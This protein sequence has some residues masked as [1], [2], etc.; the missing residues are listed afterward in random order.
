M[1][2]LALARTRLSDRDLLAEVVRLAACERAATAALIALLAEVE[3][4]KLYLVEGCSSLFGY[5]TERL[6]L[7]EHA[8][9]HRIEA[10][11]AVRAFPILLAHLE[12]GALTLTAVTLLRPHLTET[13]H[14]TLLEAARGRSKRDVEL[15]VRRLAPLPD[16]RATVR[17]LPVPPGAPAS[18][19]TGIALRASPG[20]VLVASTTCTDVVATGADAGDG[21]DV[22]AGTCT[23]AFEDSTSTV[24]QGPPCEP[25]REPAATRVGTARPSEI[26][27]LSPERYSLRVTLSA[28]AHAK[29]RRA[30]DLLRH[31]VPDGDP[32]AIVDRALTLLVD[33]LERSKFAARKEARSPAG[34]RRAEEP[35]RGGANPLDRGADRGNR[36]PTRHI[37]AA[38]RREVW[39]RDEGRCAFSGVGGRCRET[40]RLEFHHRIPVAD[41]GAASAE[42]VEL[43][44][45]AHHHYESERWFGGAGPPAGRDRR[46]RSGPS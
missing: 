38:V 20:A 29:L 42:N 40:G 1:P 37:P 36:R 16:V 26:R 9:Y 46:T 14:E 27:V 30:Q 13:N 35:P 10:A 34:L 6:H 33:H 19:P 24:D 15:L 17:K 44:C 2:P 23:P 32:A 7:S 5:C 25:A 39:A 8:A 11:R 4:R 12:S 41:G 45:T 43:R 21:R 22:G 3:A 18:P 31:A 28:D